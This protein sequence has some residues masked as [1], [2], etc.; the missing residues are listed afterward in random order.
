MVAVRKPGC[1]YLDAISAAT[2]EIA[3]KTMRAA[4][5]FISVESGISGMF[6]ME[7]VLRDKGAGLSRAAAWGRLEVTAAHL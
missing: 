5:S 3:N 1:S 2:A 4:R 7:K 6:A